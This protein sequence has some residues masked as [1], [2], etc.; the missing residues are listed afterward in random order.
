LGAADV[1]LDFLCKWKA[2]SEISQEK[3]KNPFVLVG[4]YGEELDMEGA[5]QLVAS[6]ELKGVTKAIIGEP[7]EM[8]IVYA[9]NGYGSCRF[10]IL[11]HEEE[12]N[13]IADH[14]ESTSLT[15]Q[16]KVFYGK[17]AH[18]S[19][20]HLGE[21][22]IHKLLQYL[23]RLPAGVGVLHASGGTVV[24]TVP[25]QAQIE[26][27]VGRLLPKGVRGVGQ[28][29]IKLQKEL[30]RLSREFLIYEDKNFSPPHP[31]LN[32]GVLRTERDRIWAQ[33]SFR[34]TPQIEMTKIESWWEN[35]E[36]FCHEHEIIFK[37]E[38]W[39]PPALTPKNCDLI[40]GAQEISKLLNLKTDLIT[41]ASATECSVYRQEGIDCMV[42]GPG[43]S[44]GNSHTANEYNILNQLESAVEF[45]R[46]AARKFCL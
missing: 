40:S 25:S 27:D 24:N 31:T 44:I 35:L 9:N 20:P 14:D 43:V 2:L 45:Y 46:Q 26:V 21:N 10:E 7:S 38:S 13:L 15:T 22:A 34:F 42:I 12:L 36:M 30:E 19:T 4:T 16:E 11:F 8:Q 3:L 5:K 6:G 37:K 23:E 33:V 1:K 39:T 41:K 28:R 18:S 17:A 29:L 32:L